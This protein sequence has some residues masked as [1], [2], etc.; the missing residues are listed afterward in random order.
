MRYAIV[1]LV[2]LIGVLLGACTAT[3]PQAT[4][5]A[6]PTL[7][8]LR[9]PT[10]TPTLTTP[11]NDGTTDGITDGTTDR[12][13]VRLDAGTDGQATA[14]D[15]TAES[16]PTAV[17]EAET[18]L[19]ADA[20]TNAP[21]PDATSVP[22]TP[23]PTAAL[24]LYDGLA[25]HVAED[26]T[27]LL[28]D[29]AAPIVITDYSDFLCPTCQRHVLEIEPQLVAAYVRNGRAQLAFRP[30][31]NHGERSLR[32]SEA[33]ECANQQGQF[34]AMHDLLFVRLDQLWSVPES[35]LSTLTRQF[36]VE[37]GMDDATFAACQ[38][39]GVAAQQVQAW[40]AEQRSRGITLQPTFEI[41]EQRFVGLQPFTV[42]EQVLAG[43]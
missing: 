6:T 34:W 41:G 16:M 27:P 42:F 15:G 24:P 22:P 14:P 12:E 37:L 5:P 9:Q 13:Q 11:S 43:D 20:P 29:P 33:A 26:G 38:A 7:V 3:E 10:T 1:P 21:A 28:G 32:V 36:A 19:E 23:E 30:I 40:D 35:E 2:F 17:A 39:D 31:L 8:I 18:A 4:T 25:Q